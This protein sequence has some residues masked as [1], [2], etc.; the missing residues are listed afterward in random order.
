MRSTL[1]KISQGY[2][3]RLIGGVRAITVASWAWLVMNVII[4]GRVTSG[5]GEANILTS[6]DWV[7]R[8]MREKLGFQPYPGTLNL[9]LSQEDRMLLHDGL[10]RA[11]AISLEPPMEGFARGICYKIMIMHRLEGALVFPQ[12]P[13]RRDDIVEIIAPYSLRDVL[14]VKDGDEVILE[15]K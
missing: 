7:M 5:K 13:G 4:R 8:Q 1:L 15:I 12:V 6:L 9:E 3:V 11:Q 2:D 10:S 14:N